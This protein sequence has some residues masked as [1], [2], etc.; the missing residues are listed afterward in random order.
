MPGQKP[1]I[2]GTDMSLSVGHRIQKAVAD[3]NRIG[4]TDYSESLSDAY[5]YSSTSSE[6]YFKVSGMLDFVLKNAAVS[7]EALAK[8]LKN[9][10]ADIDEKISQTP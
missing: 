6:I 4:L 5:L 10:K 9:L 7:D 1:P 8:E 3:L 2:Q